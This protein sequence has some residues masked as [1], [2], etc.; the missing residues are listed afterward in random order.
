[1]LANTD[2]GRLLVCGTNAYNPRCRYY[3][4]NQVDKEFSGKGLCPYDPKHNSTSIYAGKINNKTYYERRAAQILKGLIPQTPNLRLAQIMKVYQVSGPSGDVLP[5]L[6]SFE[7]VH[8][9][10]CLEVSHT[11]WDLCK[12][13]KTS[14]ER[15]ET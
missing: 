5:H 2:N 7:D 1:M 14:L 4:N 10:L 12:R 13:G 8:H 3:S 15:P 11:S 6:E 9:R